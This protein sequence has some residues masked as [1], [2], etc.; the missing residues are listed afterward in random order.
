R[1]SAPR[2]TPPADRG[3]APVARG[4]DWSRS[5]SGFRRRAAPAPPEGRRAQA[6]RG[7]RRRTRRARARA[8]SRAPPRARL[9]RPGPPSPRGG[10]SLL[11][12]PRRPGEEQDEGDEHVE[13]VLLQAW[14]VERAHGGELLRDPGRGALV[15]RLLEAVAGRG[16]PLERR[17]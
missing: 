12:Q 10:E 7:N 1:A 14:P 9:P 8:G 15:Q 11:H 5:G 17:R 2:T 4:Q 16:S 3:P 13:E 6:P